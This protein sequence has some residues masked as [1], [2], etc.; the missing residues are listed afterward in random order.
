MII[1]RYPQKDET[2]SYLILG[3]KNV[4]DA[5]GLDYYKMI[6]EIKAQMRR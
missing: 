4:Y 6:E 1:E 5:C 2:F 3:D